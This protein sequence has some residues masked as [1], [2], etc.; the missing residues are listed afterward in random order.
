MCF[1]LLKADVRGWRDRPPRVS[2][3]PPGTPR[4]QPSHTI[5]DLVAIF[6][7]EVACN[8]CLKL[9]LMPVHGRRSDDCYVFSFVLF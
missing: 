6:S 4:G 5:G 3:E 7:F 1:R 8:K 2:N 9:Q